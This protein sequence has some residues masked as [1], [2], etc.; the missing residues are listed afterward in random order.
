MLCKLNMIYDSQV[1]SHIYPPTQWLVRKITTTGQ[2]S[3]Y[4]KHD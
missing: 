4:A 2:A 3:A 1:L